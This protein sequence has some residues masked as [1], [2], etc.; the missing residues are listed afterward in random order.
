MGPTQIHGT[1]GP[2]GT[3]TTRASVTTG[4]IIVDQM[5][6]GCGPNKSAS[7]HLTMASGGIGKTA[8]TGLA[9]PILTIVGMIS[10]K[11]NAT[12]TSRQMCATLDS[13]IGI[14]ILVL[15]EINIDSSG[16]ATRN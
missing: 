10:C 3:C 8:P 6:T 13:L 12:R 14:L 16:T 11:R 9:K 1:S 4:T 7:Q 2:V 5:M 15:A